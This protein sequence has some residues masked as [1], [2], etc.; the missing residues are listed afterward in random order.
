MNWP[1][2]KT[3]YGCEA[4]G[5]GND[6]YLTRWTLLDLPAFQVCLHWF[7][8]SDADDRHDHPWPFLSLILWRGYVEDTPYGRKRRWPGSIAFRSADWI[9]RVELLGGRGALTLV[10]MGKRSRVWGFHTPC[11]W[12]EWTTYFKQK[13]C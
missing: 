10:V 4:R 11:G 2:R 7:H 12:V 3:I 9:H 5:D 13:G 1:A 6:A 8:R